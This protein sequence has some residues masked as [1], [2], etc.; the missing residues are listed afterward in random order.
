MSAARRQFAAL[1]TDA[2]IGL[3]DSDKPTLTLFLSSFTS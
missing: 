1:K 2:S 3:L